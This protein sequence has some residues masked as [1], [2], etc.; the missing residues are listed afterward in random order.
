MLKYKLKHN[1]KFFVKV[2]P[3]YTSK[4]CNICGYVKEN[5]ML[6]DREYLCENFGNIIHKDINAA[7]NILE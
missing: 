6:K 3:Q 2:N 1:G 5:L 7:N 4:T